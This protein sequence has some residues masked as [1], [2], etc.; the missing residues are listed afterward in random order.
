MIIC[1]Q[2]LHFSLKVT[3]LIRNHNFS[4][5]LTISK[6][7]TFFT[8]DITIFTK[9]SEV[10]CHWNQSQFW[11]YKQLKF[12]FYKN[13]IFPEF[14]SFTKISIFTKI[15]IFDQKQYFQQKKSDNEKKIFKNHNNI[16]PNYTFWKKKSLPFTENLE[17]FTKRSNF[18]QTI[19][20]FHSW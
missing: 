20:F 6:K 19:L 9:K 15:H 16:P 17:F 14:K 1:H 18:S 8:K 4:K 13:H 12:I 11:L 10:I 7:F 3:I 2:N 5:K